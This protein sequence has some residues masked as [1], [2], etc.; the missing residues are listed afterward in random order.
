MPPELLLERTRRPRCIWLAGS[1]GGGAP[2]SIT[3][4]TFMRFYIFIALTVVFICAGCA[5]KPASLAVAQGLVV[6]PQRTDWSDS[7]YIEIIPK[8]IPSD[9]IAEVFY[10]VHSG[11]TPARIANHVGLSMHQLK[12]INPFTDFHALKIGNLIKIYR[13]TVQS[14]S[15]NQSPSQSP[16]PTPVDSGSSASRS[17]P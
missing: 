15:P 16:E 9:S 6:V 2:L 7:N 4:G 8:H 1:V 12:E 11:D 13:G 10:I 3:L 5:T 14:Y 17:A